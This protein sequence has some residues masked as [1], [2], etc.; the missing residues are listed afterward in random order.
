M[1]SVKLSVSSRLLLAKFWGSQK[2]YAPVLF[3]SQLYYFL[4]VW[5][6][7]KWILIT[8][9]N[10]LLLLG[11]FLLYFS[12]FFL[13]VLIFLFPPPSSGIQHLSH[14]LSQ[15]YLLWY[16]LLLQI[17]KNLSELFSPQFTPLSFNTFLSAPGIGSLHAQELKWLPIVC[18][19]NPHL[20]EEHSVLWWSKLKP[21]K[22]SLSSL[23]SLEIFPIANASPLCRLLIAT[24]F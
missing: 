13:S 23:S 21:K 12:Y 5:T 11:L 15:N 7:S 20:S 14:R 16:L 8:Q 24:W 22:L 1:L 17:I 10:F 9:E 6:H 18:S 4:E 19:W 2:F 3:K